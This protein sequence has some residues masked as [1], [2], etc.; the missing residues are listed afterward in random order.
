ML[1]IIQNHKKHY[2]NFLKK[3]SFFSYEFFILLCW[4]SVE[5]KLFFVKK[6]L[7]LL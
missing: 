6:I 1:Y 5:N 7:I 4:G 3:Q 2:Y